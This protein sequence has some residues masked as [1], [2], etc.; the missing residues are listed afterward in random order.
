MQPEVSLRTKVEELKRLETYGYQ[1]AYFILQN[2]HMAIE[3][4]KTA[5][6]ELI[7]DPSFFLKPLS[8][9]RDIMKKTMMRRSIAVKQNSVGACS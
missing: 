2:E 3:A 5:L 6:L 9:R 7:G 1:V 4:T 8:V